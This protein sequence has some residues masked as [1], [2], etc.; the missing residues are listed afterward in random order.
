MFLELISHHAAASFSNSVLLDGVSDLKI[1]LESG[2]ANPFSPHA[3]CCLQMGDV[4]L[5]MR[6]KAHDQ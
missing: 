1:L 2:Y 6:K 3:C 5:Q 4:D